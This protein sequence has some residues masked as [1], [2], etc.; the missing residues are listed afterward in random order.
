GEA[1]NSLDSFY[2][3][4]ILKSTDGGDSWTLLGGNPGKNEFSQR[5]VNKIV[6]SPTD[7]STVYAAVSGVP[8]NKFGN[9]ATGDDNGQKGNC[10]I[11]KS[12]DGGATWT[13]TTILI[14]NLDE[15]TDLVMDPTD[16]Q[17]LWAAVGTWTGKSANGVYLTTDGGGKWTAAGNFP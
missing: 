8:I 11:W 6:A 14:S 1:N 5:V 7:P 16:P 9:P 3:Q 12:T 17:K 15:Y 4:G 10:G 13:D 2:G